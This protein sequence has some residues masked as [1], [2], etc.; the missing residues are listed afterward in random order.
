MNILYVF[1]GQGSQYEGMGKDISEAFEVA[2]EV[3][4][5][6]SDVLG[7]DIRDMS[8]NNPDDQ[9]NLTRYTQ[10]ALLTHHIAC[11]E[12]FKEKMGDAVQ[13]TMAAGHSLG[14]YSALVAANALTFE[15]ALK[16]VQKRGEVDD[17]GTRLHA[18]H[19]V[20]GHEPGRGLAGDR[21]GGDHHVVGRD[22]RCHQ[23]ALLA[24]EVL[25]ECLGVAA[26]VLGRTGLELHLDELAAETLHLFF[27]RGPNVVGMDYAA[28]LLGGGDGLETGDAGA[29]DEHLRRRDGAGC[30]HHHR[31]HLGQVVRRQNDGLVAGDVALRGQGEGDDSQFVSGSRY[32]SGAGGIPESGSRPWRIGCSH[33][34]GNAF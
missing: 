9:L 26:R 5:T 6:A 28:E 31:E 8:F 7:Y 27:D 1:P 34:G 3:Y 2:A 15:T 25:S 22:H 29:H 21:G 16:L 13:P 33:C 4:D 14:E 17:D 11:L 30:G 32:L 18:L 10:P 24:V 23:L 20:L 19:H 12:V